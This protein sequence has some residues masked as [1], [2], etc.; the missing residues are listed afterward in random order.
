[1]QRSPNKSSTITKLIN[2]KGKDSRKKLTLLLTNLCDQKTGE[3]DDLLL[4][5]INQLS[6]QEI[7]ACLDFLQEDYAIP[8]NRETH[9]LFKKIYWRMILSEHPD[10]LEIALRKMNFLELFYCMMLAEVNISHMQSTDKKLYDSQIKNRK[11]AQQLLLIKLLKQAKT[12]DLK[13]IF[14]A[15]ETHLLHDKTIKSLQDVEKSFIFSRLVEVIKLRGITEQQIFEYCLLEAAYSNYNNVKF[16]LE[17]KVD[18]NTPHIS[19]AMMRSDAKREACTDVP[20][21]SAVIEDNS[22][23]L[24]IINLLIEYKADVNFVVTNVT[25]EIGKTRTTIQPNIQP[26]TKCDSQERLHQIKKDK[27]DHPFIEFS[28]GFTPLIFAAKAGRIKTMSRLLQEKINVNATTLDGHS[29]LFYAAASGNIEMIQLLLTHGADPFLTDH[30]GLSAMDATNDNNIKNGIRKYIAT[31]CLEDL[32]KE[33][34]AISIDI[35]QYLINQL[36]PHI[37]YERGEILINI[38]TLREKIKKGKSKHNSSLMTTLEKF[39]AQM[40]ITNE[41]VSIVKDKIATTSEP[42]ITWSDLLTTLLQC[43]EEYSSVAE[44]KQETFKKTELSPSN[45]KKSETI[46]TTPDIH[47]LYNN[48]VIATDSN[49][50][51]ELKSDRKDNLQTNANKH[52]IESTQLEL[53]YLTKELKAAVPKSISQLIEQT[54]AMLYA[55]GSLMRK[56]VKIH[57]YFTQTTVDTLFPSKLAQHLSNVHFHSHQSPLFFIGGNLRATQ[58]YCNAIRT[59]IG[60]IVDQMKSNPRPD[61]DSAKMAGILTSSLFKALQQH[62]IPEAT[63]AD[64]IAQL[65]LV[66]RELKL[67]ERAANEEAHSNKAVDS[68]RKQFAKCFT[69]AARAAPYLKWHLVLNLN[70]LYPGIH[71]KLMETLPLLIHNGDVT[72]ADQENINKTFHIVV[73]HIQKIGGMLRHPTLATSNTETLARIG[74]LPAASSQNGSANANNEQNKG[75]ALIQKHSV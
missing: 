22:E 38:P 9:V 74:L 31:C 37:R 34:K 18:P 46:T 21:F 11:H 52:K 27:S 13:D 35:I 72:K 54:N 45:E 15:M 41:L 51:Q 25:S 26:E 8:S 33:P 7:E 43:S 44:T 53:D 30:D 49:T 62:V 63:D 71:N 17:N 40:I 42:N 69:L 59:M 47:T 16:L 68:Q 39:P 6:V 20:L 12:Q 2:I 24:K 60:E 29:A 3:G 66:I 64:C 5:L 36:A 58:R 1:M 65:T 14:Y 32:S 67:Y 10:K 73:E 75:L 19:T 55:F 56:I 70:V 28:Y 61:N 4:R 23:S 50:S 57:E 48:I